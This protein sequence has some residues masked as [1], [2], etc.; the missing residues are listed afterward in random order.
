MAE[1]K[2]LWTFKGGWT[3]KSRWAHFGPLRNS[4]GH[5]WMHFEIL[6]RTR[7]P[8]LPTHR[9]GPSPTGPVTALSKGPSTPL[10]CLIPPPE[11]QSSRLP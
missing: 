8:G 9:E 4:R 11:R 10:F 2:R 1:P 5:G 6:V 3:F 7:A